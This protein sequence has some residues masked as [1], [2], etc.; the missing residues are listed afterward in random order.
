MKSQPQSTR[1]IN[2]TEQRGNHPFAIPEVHNKKGGKAS[3]IDVD[4]NGE[5]L[6][7]LNKNKTLEQDQHHSSSMNLTIL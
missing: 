3:I 4:T 1:S 7:V 6:H 2:V 5:H